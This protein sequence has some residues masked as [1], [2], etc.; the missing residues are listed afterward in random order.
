[1]GDYYWYYTLGYNGETIEDE[2]RPSICYYNPKT[3]MMQLIGDDYDVT[4]SD[5][6]FRILCPVQP[7]LVS[8]LL[9]LNRVLVYDSRDFI[10]DVTTPC[11]MLMRPATVVREYDGVEGDKL[12]DVVFDHRPT[13]CS[14]GHFAD[15]IVVAEYTKHDKR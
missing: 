8:K 6:R 9:Q 7:F 13:E 11:S 4:F 1:M 10:D 14:H 5:E 3:G 12:V 2:G 15:R